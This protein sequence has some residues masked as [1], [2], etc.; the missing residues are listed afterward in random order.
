MKILKEQKLETESYVQNVKIK[1]VTNREQYNLTKNNVIRT[2]IVYANIIQIYGQVYA[3]LKPIEKSNQVV[4]NLYYCAYSL[5][6]SMFILLSFKYKAN[7]NFVTIGTVLLSFKCNI[8]VFDF[9]K[10]K[11]LMNFRDWED[12]VSN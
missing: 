9:E 2:I 5:L 12:I 3:I 1:N 6:A 10:T 11:D 7:N 4:V 8:R